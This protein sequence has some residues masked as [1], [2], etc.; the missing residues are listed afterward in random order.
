MPIG[1]EADVARGREIA[2]AP[3]RV[4]RSADVLEPQ[5]GKADRP[6]APSQSSA[7]S[8]S[9]KSLLETALRGRMAAGEVDG[10]AVAPRGG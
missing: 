5:Y 8:A 2:L 4:L 6:P 10:K 3:A 9:V 1:S 7:A